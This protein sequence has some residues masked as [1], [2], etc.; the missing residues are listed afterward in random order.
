MDEHLLE[1]LRDAQRF[2]FFGSRPIEQAAQHARGFVD[3]LGHLEPGHHLVDLGSGGGLPGLV[4]ADAY[5]DGVITLIDRR[6]KRTDFLR[7]AAMR[8][9][10]DHVEVITADVSDLIAEV[11]AGNRPPFDAATARGFGPPSVTLSMAC[12]LIGPDGRIVISE[13]PSGDRWD[14]E[15][16]RSLGVVREP[17]GHVSVFRRLPPLT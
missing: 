16:I 5:R 4:L 1:T 13:P 7:R 9:G 17:A 2:G 15:L 8:L 10:Y 6:Q 3:A 14:P 12:A 11:D